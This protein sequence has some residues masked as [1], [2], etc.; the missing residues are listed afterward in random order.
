MLRSFGGPIPIEIVRIKYLNTIV[1]Q[2][3]PVIKKRIRQMLGF[4]SFTSASAR[5]ADIPHSWAVTHKA[6]PNLPTFES[7]GTESTICEAA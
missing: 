5:R 2:D 3:H 1:E 4:K 6:T 7:S